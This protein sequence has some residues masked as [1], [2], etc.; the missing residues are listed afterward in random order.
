MLHVRGA[1]L[2]TLDT[3]AFFLGVP[4][5]SASAFFSSLLLL[6]ALVLSQQ[7][8]RMWETALAH[9][10]EEDLRK[11]TARNLG[12]MSSERARGGGERERQRRGS[13]SRYIPLADRERSAHQLVVKAG[14]VSFLP[15]P[16]PRGVLG[17]CASP[18]VPALRS[19]Q[20]RPCCRCCRSSFLGKQMLRWR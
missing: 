5:P 17:S 19:Q 11:H 6:P 14:W 18:P 20:T 2:Y 16:H 1:I 4:S 12:M 10:E 8:H 7:T 13:G 15:T 9:G 3:G